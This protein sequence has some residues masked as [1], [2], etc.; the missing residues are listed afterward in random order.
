MKACLAL[1]LAS[2][3]AVAVSPATAGTQTGF[4][5]SIYVRDSDGLILVNL[6]MDETYFP[7]HPA[8]GWQTYWVVP[9]ETTASG[10]RLFATLLAA[11]ISGRHVTILG[12]NTCSRWGDGEDID[13][14]GV[15]GV[16]S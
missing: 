4:I 5:K 11:Q 16:V 12:K 2:M 3:C 10:K 8:C 6:F 13:T 9:N 14:V 1:L 7:N 15:N